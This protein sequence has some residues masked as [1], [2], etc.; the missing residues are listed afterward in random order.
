MLN[1]TRATSVIVA[2]PDALSSAPGALAFPSLEVESKCPPKIT[3]SSG[4]SEP[5]IVI[6]TE[7]IGVFV[8]LTSLTEIS[9]LALL[10][11]SHLA[12]KSTA[13]C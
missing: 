6:T 7:D 13:D 3:Y 1:N 10:M 2:I 11:F 12:F 8:W 9:L 4:F 5:V